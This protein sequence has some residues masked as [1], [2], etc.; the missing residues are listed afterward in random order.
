[1]KKQKFENEVLYTISPMSSFSIEPQD[2]NIIFLPFLNGSNEDPLAKG[3]L[4]PDCLPISRNTYVAVVRE[5]LSH[6]EPCQRQQNC[7]E[8][9]NVRRVRLSERPNCNV[10]RVQIFADALQLPIDAIEDKE[11]D[12]QGASDGSRYC[13][14]NL[15]RLLQMQ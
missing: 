8:T 5:L 7:R 4:R 10:M 13:S 12:A 14:R 2:N 9:V 15:Q 3:T 6:Y 11:L 1:M